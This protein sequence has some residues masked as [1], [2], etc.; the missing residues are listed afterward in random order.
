MALGE[1]KTLKNIVLYLLKIESKPFLSFD[2][3]HMVKNKFVE[4]Q[5]I[6]LIAAIQISPWSL[7]NW[8]EK[9]RT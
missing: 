2:G 3:C 1:C 4:K 7:N 5:G 9:H 6:F 8:A